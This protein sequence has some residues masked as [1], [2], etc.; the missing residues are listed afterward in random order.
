MTNWSRLEQ[1]GDIGGFGVVYKCVDANG[2]E[3]GY[4]AM[5]LLNKDDED[6]K[7]RFRREVRLASKLNH[8]RIVRV[9]E[10]NLHNDPYFYVMPLY[11]CSL[12][13]L[14]PQLKGDYDRIRCIVNNILDG[15]EY[16]H[17]EGVFH[18]DLKPQNILYNS[19]NDLVITDFGLGVEPDSVSQQRLTR[20]NMGMGTDFFTA[21]EQWIDFKN[22]DARADIYSLGAIIYLLFIQETFASRMEYSNLPVGI[23]FVVKQCT[24]YNRDHRFNDVAGVRK[25]FNAAVD[26]L[27]HQANETYY[28]DVINE[29]KAGKTDDSFIDI[30]SGHLKDALKRPDDIHDIFMSINPIQFSVL[31]ERHYDLTLEAL[32]KFQEQ[33]TG[34]GW[35]FS[36][37]DTIGRQCQLLYLNSDINELRAIFLYI[38]VEVGS[39]HNRWFVMDIARSLLKGIKNHAE[40]ME[41]AT[42]LEPL[43]YELKKLNIESHEVF[44][45][46]Q[47]LFNNGAN[48]EH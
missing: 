46:L 1:I 22:V 27:T 6:S 45:Q 11:T 8:P 31:C 40:A 14:M 42:Y 39:N 38:I 5:K 4:Y 7:A 10:P 26:L 47:Q 2:K 34:Q 15:V 24:Q 35:G 13:A 44:G 9:V 12:S 36:Y 28:S 19:D 21:P 18:R 30:F 23:D 33:V 20:T 29:L 48:K 3:P 41:I 25:A 16:L 37:T 43:D 32:R 17:N